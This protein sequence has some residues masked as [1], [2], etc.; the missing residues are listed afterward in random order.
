MMNQS[1]K[2][3]TIQKKMQAQLDLPTAV[4]VSNGEIFIADMNNHRVRKVLWNGQIVTIAGT[5]VAGYNGDDQPATSAQIN[6]PICVVVSI[7]FT[8]RNYIEFE[9]LIRMEL[10]QQLQEMEWEDTM[11]MV[12][13]L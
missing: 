10:F 1:F 7:K 4:F 11:E 12:N 2:F 8:F 5:G 13:L 3:T 9:R 6:G